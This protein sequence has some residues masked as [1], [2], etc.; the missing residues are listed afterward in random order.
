[1]HKRLTKLVGNTDN[2][3]ISC[4]SFEDCRETIKDKFVTTIILD[5][6]NGFYSSIKKIFYDKPIQLIHISEKGED[7]TDLLEK[8]YNDFIRYPF[9]EVEFSVRLDA[10]FIRFQQQRNI[11]EE[12][13][14]FRKAVQNEEALSSKILDKHIHLKKAF[15]NIEDINEELAVSN[16]KLEQIAKYDIL[17]GLLNR[18]SLFSIIDME[19]S[20][21]NRNYAPITGMMMDID[22]F[23]D[24]N[25]NHG[26]L[27]GDKVIKAFGEQLN[28]TLRKY[29]HA[30]RF[31]GEEFFVILPNTK[32]GQSYKIAE[33][34][35]K[36]LENTKIHE[37]GKKISVTVSIGIAEL[38][39]NEA[40]D[41]WLMRTD[42]AMYKAKKSGRNQTTLYT[43]GN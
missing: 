6:D 28:M 27:V 9:D 15:Q 4:T 17:S 26:H 37:S 16:K 36:L 38:Q 31:G 21:S 19:I 23:K 18:M 10:A 1:M 14:F 11:M 35:R 22:N 5:E 42:Q 29:D 7:I 41:N 3:F 40:R 20:R 13:N 2:N 12:R 39:K 32:Q 24:I 30:G 43:S 8:G 25:D 33:R 34:F